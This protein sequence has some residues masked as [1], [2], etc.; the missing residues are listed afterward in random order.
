MTSATTLTI[1]GLEFTIADPYTAG[2]TLTENEASALNQTRAENIRNNMAR[3]I[4]EAK[5]TAAKDNDIDVASV[6][7]DMVDLEDLTTRVTEYATSYQFGVRT[8]GYTS[9]NPVERIALDIARLNV[10]AAISASPKASLGDFKG[11]QITSMAKA[12]LESEKGASIMDEARRQHEV[13]AA[14]SDSV[15][16]VSLMG[17][18]G[19]TEDEAA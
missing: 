10:R 7:A 12:L 13:L 18:D 5:E 19:N 8:I 3:I 6:T 2:H 16:L 14:A 15:D 4:K 9:A 1:Q 17:D 11:A